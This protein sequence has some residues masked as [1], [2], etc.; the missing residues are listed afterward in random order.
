MCVP[1]PSSFQ[2]HSQTMFHT[3]AFALFRPTALVCIGATRPT[4]HSIFVGN[5]A[6]NLKAVDLEKAFAKFGKVDRARIVADRETGR[7]KGFGCA[8]PWLSKSNAR[9]S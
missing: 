9:W 7:S 1:C 2:T 5:L 8:T 3:T 6:W 4:L